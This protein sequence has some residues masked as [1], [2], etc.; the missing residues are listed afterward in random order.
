MVEDLLLQYI[1]IF[2]SNEPYVRI[3]QLTKLVLII[4]L[5]FS[6][7]NILNISHN[8]QR[9]CSFL[10]FDAQRWLWLTM[11]SPIIATFSA[12][13]RHDSTLNNALHSSVARVKYARSSQCSKVASTYK[14]VLLPPS[15]R[16]LHPTRT[17]LIAASFFILVHCSRDISDSLDEKK[18]ANKGSSSCDR[19]SKVNV[20]VYT[21]CSLVKGYVWRSILTEKIARFHPRLAVKASIFLRIQLSCPNDYHGAVIWLDHNVCCT[22]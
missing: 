8:S 11:F 7:I 12:Q 2:Q 16:H 19:L 17:Y 22:C 1:T 15:R 5:S 21:S 13:L 3:S 9:C 10:V 14:E 4:L 20:V 18:T 6:I